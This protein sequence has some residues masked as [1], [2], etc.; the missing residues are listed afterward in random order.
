MPNRILTDPEGWRHESTHF[1]HLFNTQTSHCSVLLSFM[2]HREQWERH[3][4]KYSRV[5]NRADSPLQRHYNFKLDK[6]PQALV[7]INS[8]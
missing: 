4:D 5:S 3:G 6:A 8:L 1:R 2:T 7:S